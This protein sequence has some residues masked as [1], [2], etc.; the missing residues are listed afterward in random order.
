MTLIGQ[1]SIAELCLTYRIASLVLV[2]RCR[3]YS[4]RRASNL[5]QA[6]GGPHW[7]RLGRIRCRGDGRIVNLSLP[8]VSLAGEPLEPAIDC[9]R[10]FLFGSHRRLRW[11][12]HNCPFSS[13]SKR[14]AAFSRSR[15]SGLWCGTHGCCRDFVSFT[16]R[17]PGSDWSASVWQLLDCSCC[18]GKSI[19]W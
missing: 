19:S 18:A 16:K 13:L 8:R 10:N 1:R 7:R 14:R 9:A 2:R 6:R 17:Y 4:L 3:R 15:N 11:R 5:Y 12:R